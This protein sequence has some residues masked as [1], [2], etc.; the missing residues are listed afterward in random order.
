MK[1]GRSDADHAVMLS[2]YLPSRR[3]ELVRG[4]SNK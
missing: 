1:Q 3:H 2:L 4:A